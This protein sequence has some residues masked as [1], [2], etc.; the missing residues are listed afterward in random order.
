MSTR[1]NMYIECETFCGEIGS[2]AYPGGDLWEA[3]TSKEK[4]SLDE[5]MTIVKEFKNDGEGVGNW[6]YEF[7]WHP[8]NPLEEY[9]DYANW[10]G[11]ILVRD[12]NHDLTWERFSSYSQVPNA[13]ELIS[14]FKEKE[15]HEKV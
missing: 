4:Y 13:W 11:V 9:R 1:A 12:I 14:Q 5:Y 7:N 6:S 8:T 15:E 2:D 3:L 10:E